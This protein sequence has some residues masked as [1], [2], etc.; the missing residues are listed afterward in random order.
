M[1]G[2]TQYLF[3]GPELYDI[4]A[5]FEAERNERVQRIRRNW[6][7]Y[8][9][10]MPEPLKV[11]Q[12]GVN[13]N[14]LFPKIGQVADRVVSFLLGDGVEF[15][16]GGDDEQDTTDDVLAQVWL[17]NHK[18][19]LLYNIALTGALAGHVF[20]RVEPQTE[21]SPLIT[22]L[23]PETCAVFWDV[24]DYKRVL[25]YRLQYQ[26]NETGPGKRIDYVQGRFANGQF[27]HQV[28][29]EWWEVVY[30]T[31][32]G[33][34]A[35]WELVG[36]PRL[37]ALE[38][39]PLV[40]WQNL[41]NPFGYYGY[42]DVS[43]AVRLNAALNFVAS[44]FNLVLMHHASPK[45]VG[46]GF[47]AGEVVTTEVGGL[48]TI[49]KPRGEVDLFNLEMQ[50]DLSSSARFMEMLDEE[51]WHS[52]RMIDPRTLKDK[53]GALTNFGLRVMFTDALKKTETKRALYSDGLERLCR[54]ILTVM[55]VAAPQTIEVIWSDILPESVQERT[56]TVLRRL[57]AKIID[58][59]TA[60]EELGY[61]H[62]EIEERMAEVGQGE[63]N[64]GE[65]LLRN[66]ERG[67][68]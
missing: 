16:S 37:L 22:N 6:N 48:Y 34:G 17:D 50:S 3:E 57:E 15:D 13:P 45:T 19:R 18:N 53:V 20:V 21:G 41:P 44:N 47:D 7:Y 55:G 67:A 52:V 24:S 26:V 35:K 32:G 63:T 43:T 56:E 9:G 66:F 39:A 28:E 25:W 51:I 12:D 1:P 14:V 46:I 58:L 54:H 11:G 2:V 10:A 29:G 61:D 8:N 60:R 59:K 33:Y 68:M 30:T 64:L 23:N 31:R 4:E 49:N 5:A 40:D 65:I 27:D 38:S 42:D 62:D 36:Q